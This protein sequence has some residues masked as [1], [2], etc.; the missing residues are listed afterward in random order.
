MLAMIG[1]R[2]RRGWRG[3]VL[4]IVMAALLVGATIGAAVAPACADEAETASPPTPS[5]TP[6]PTPVPFAAVTSANPLVVHTLYTWYDEASFKKAAVQPLEQFTSDDPDYYRRYFS[7]LRADGVDVIAG[8]LT[9]LPGERGKDGKPLPTVYQAENLVRILP[10]IGA[11][12][13]KTFA[14]YD[15][16]IRSYWKNGLSASQLD[17]A[18]PALRRQLLDDMG[19]IA[20]EMVKK[21]MDGYLFLQDAEGRDVVDEDGLKRPVIAIYIARALK[22]APGFPNVAQVLDRELAG[23]F[24]R[25]GLGRPALVLDAIFW[26]PRAFDP[27]LVKAFGRNAVALTAFCPVTSRPD[28]TKLGDWVPL[29]ERLYHDA[30]GQLLELVKRGELDREV[31]IWPGV[32]PNFETRTD[33]SGKTRSL[34]EWEA[35]LRM[36]L[37]ATRRLT[38]DPREEPIRAMTVIYAD[39]YYEGTPLISAGPFGAQPLTV[40]GNVLKDA[41][42]WLERF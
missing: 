35:M 40:Q 9:G 33:R 5:P 12:G 17:M 39:E 22:D 41:G 14:Y 15:T 4:R 27:G 1:R 16:A 30:A 32:M 7:R 28:V 21:N 24:H 38:P 3:G 23:L 18:N 31:Q 6:S 36:G 20:D 11:A 19:W 2:T 25:R 42:I 26:G 8:V 34:A 29:F 10:V 13:M 37:T